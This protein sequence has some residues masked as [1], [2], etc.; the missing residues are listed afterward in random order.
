MMVTGEQEKDTNKFAEATVES[1]ENRWISREHY[2]EVKSLD[3][4]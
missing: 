3:W 4:S 2:K 1:R